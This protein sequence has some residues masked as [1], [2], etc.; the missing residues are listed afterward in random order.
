MHTSLHPF[1]IAKQHNNCFGQYWK[2]KC[3]TC[4]NNFYKAMIAFKVAK[5]NTLISYICQGSSENSNQ[6]FDL[7]QILEVITLEYLENCL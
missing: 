2:P 7:L 4:S 1:E 5:Q 3:Q 6:Y